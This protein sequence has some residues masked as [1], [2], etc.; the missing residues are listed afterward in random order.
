[1]I[2]VRASVADDRATLVSLARLARTALAGQRGGA[3]LLATLPTPT[4]RIDGSSSS[5][6]GSIG[7]V[8][9]G[10]ACLAIDGEQA[11]VTELFVEPPARSVGVGHLLIE[12]LL[13]RAGI[14]GCRTID[15]CALPG[16]RATKN[17]FEAHAMTARL[18]VVSRR[19]DADVDQS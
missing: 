18:L 7:G 19:L 2:E 11:T 17:F 16:D 3:E 1:M 14:A 10:Y 8:A 13:I 12:A 9:V 6:V 4:A 15:A 5:F